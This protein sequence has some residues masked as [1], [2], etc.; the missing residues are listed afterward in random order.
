M[1]SKMFRRRRLILSRLLARRKALRIELLEDRRVMAVDGW[2]NV[3][4]PLSVLNVPSQDVS[5]LDVLSIINE[6][7]SPRY[8]DPLGRL[9]ATVPSNERPPYYDVNCNGFVDPLDALS[10]INHLN[11]GPKPNGWRPIDLDSHAGAGFIA[12]ASCSPK[13]VEGHS[14]RTTLKSTL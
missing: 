8:S 13:L 9:P 10:L 2:T 7:N 1:F 5:P 14:L 3:L 4:Q 12:N 11:G 6:I